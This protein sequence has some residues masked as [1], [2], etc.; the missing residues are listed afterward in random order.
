MFKIYGLQGERAIDSSKLPDS[1]QET[2]IFL[3][4]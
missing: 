2:S 1:Y 3:H 4:L